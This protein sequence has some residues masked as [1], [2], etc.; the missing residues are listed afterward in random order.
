VGPPQY[1]PC[2]GCLRLDSYVSIKTSSKLKGLPT[3]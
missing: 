3:A 1:P 2:F